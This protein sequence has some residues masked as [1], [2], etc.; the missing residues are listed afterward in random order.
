MSKSVHPRIHL[1]LLPKATKRPPKEGG[2]VAMG[3]R[4][5]PLNDALFPASR[6]LMEL[7]IEQLQNDIQRDMLPELARL[8]L[9]A[10]R[11]FDGR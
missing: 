10:W 9:M 1:G 11:W 8:H 4:A 5:L 3:R 7:G 2:L 6:A